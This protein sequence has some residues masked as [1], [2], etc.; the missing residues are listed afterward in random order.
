MR[1]SAHF[2]AK[3]LVPAGFYNYQKSMSVFVVIL[4]IPQNW[5][6]SSA[7]STLRNFRGDGEG[8]RF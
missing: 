7:L 6:F 3:L 5:K 1:D 2:T 8:V 4:Y